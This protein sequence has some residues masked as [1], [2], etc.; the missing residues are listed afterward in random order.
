MAKK[1]RAKKSSASRS[2]R[3]RGSIAPTGVNASQAG[4]VD[5]AGVLREAGIA[6]E[7]IP[8]TIATIRAISDA[9]AGEG[10]P[11]P[12][13]T[14]APLDSPGEMNVATAGDAVVAEANRWRQRTRAAISAG[15]ASTLHAHQ[16]HLWTWEWN[17]LRGKRPRISFVGRAIHA[18]TQRPG[19]VADYITIFET[20]DHEN[21]DLLPDS[22]Q[23]AIDVVLRGPSGQTT[24][25]RRNEK[26]SATSA[27]RKN[28]D[29]RLEWLTGWLRYVTAQKGCHKTDYRLTRLGSQVFNNWPDWHAPDAIPVN[30]AGETDAEGADAGEEPSGD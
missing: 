16:D 13:P 11:P 12:A 19:C 27:L 24:N 25:E 3:R 4:G 9:Q 17:A 15:R 1:K 28:L 10:T 7:R 18:N 20:I 30:N 23:R 14:P 26:K 2:R 29:H 5:L 6:E 8:E 21:R 22:L